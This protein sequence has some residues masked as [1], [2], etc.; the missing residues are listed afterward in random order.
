MISYA[1]HQIHIVEAARAFFAER[2]KNRTR[3]SSKFDKK[4]V[5]FLGIGSK[6]AND[7]KPES[8]IKDTKN[9]KY[10]AGWGK[11]FSF[12]YNAKHKNELPYYDRYP[13]VLILKNNRKKRM[14]TGI[15]LHYVPPVL[16]IQLLRNIQ[17]L[18]M[19]GMDRYFVKDFFGDINRWARRIA[20]PCLHHYR[21]DKVIN[22]RLWNIP[23]LLVGWINQVKDETFIKTGT[24][25]V[26]LDSRRQ[27]FRGARW[28][29]RQKARQKAAREQAAHEKYKAKRASAATKSK[30][31]TLKK[32]GMVKPKSGMSKTSRK[33]KARTGKRYSR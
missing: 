27:M 16:R 13:L 14:F 23:T 26:W 17:H 18:Y 30:S 10:I 1:R 25:R 21:M 33:S 15:N 11:V 22:A 32:S 8:V 19:E 29:E 7:K 3:I 31:R 2:N 20:K 12:R 24:A 6:G 28:K 4:A 5:K 9:F